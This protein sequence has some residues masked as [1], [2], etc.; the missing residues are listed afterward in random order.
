MQV[1]GVSILNGGSSNIASLIVGGTF[2]GYNTGPWPS[3]YTNNAGVQIG[4]NNVISSGATDFLA[5]LQSAG[6]N[7]TS[8]I[9]SFWW[10]SSNNT[11]KIQAATI[12]QNGSY[13]Q[14]S[15]YRL[16][17]NIVNLDNKSI[18]FDKL[19]P[20][21]YTHKITGSREM[22]LIAHELQKEFP[23]LVSGD[24]D[25][26]NYQTVN[27]TGLI[28]ILIKEIQE[29]KKINNE[30]KYQIDYILTRMKRIKF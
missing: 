16:K 20:V 17:E 15:D 29:L 13:T 6:L 19:R 26:E 22:G 24:L 4:W 8:P 12:N 28:P 5:N 2:G 3:P 30:Q 1:N 21:E 9:F 10:T 27:Y 23:S 18:L 25:A 7:S 14:V 11:S